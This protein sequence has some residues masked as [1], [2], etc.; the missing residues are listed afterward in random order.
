MNIT[1]KTIS[2]IEITLVEGS[3]NFYK[4]QFLDENFEVA[5][6]VRDVKT[7]NEYIYQLYTG[8]VTPELEYIVTE[9]QIKN[10]KDKLSYQNIDVDTWPMDVS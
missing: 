1:V 10:L 5:E 4:A 7:F 8:V 3:G 9:D 6:I 2:R